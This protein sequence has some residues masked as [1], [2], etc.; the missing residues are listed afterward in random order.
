MG[1]DNSSC[2]NSVSLSLELNDGVDVYMANTAPVVGF[3]FRFVVLHCLELQ[4]VV[5]MLRFFQ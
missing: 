4:V 1:G 3:Q 2:D 5:Q